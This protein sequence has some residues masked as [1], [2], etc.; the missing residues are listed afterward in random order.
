MHELYEEL[1]PDVENDFVLSDT[2]RRGLGLKP[3]RS[4]RR[5]Q[6]Y[7]HLH[8]CCWDLASCQL[9]VCTAESSRLRKKPIRKI[10][11]LSSLNRDCQ[12]RAYTFCSAPKME[13]DRTSVHAKICLSSLCGSISDFDLSNRSLRNLVS[14][15]IKPSHPVVSAALVCYEHAS[16]G[17]ILI[18]D[19]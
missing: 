19:A 11:L 1:H 16:T 8:K 15:W 2:S 12:V 5:L 18:S 13:E 3:R 10:D 6:S 7:M 17:E 9:D 14:E 4:R